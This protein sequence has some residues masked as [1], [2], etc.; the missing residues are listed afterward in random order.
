MGCFIRCVKQPLNGKG[1]SGVVLTGDLPFAVEA[2]D[3]RI[4]GSLGVVRVCL[5]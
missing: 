2:T 1:R 5:I 3:V 4:E